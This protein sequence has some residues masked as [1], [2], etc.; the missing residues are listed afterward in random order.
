VLKGCVLRSTRVPKTLSHSSL[1]QSPL[2]EKVPTCRTR[3]SIDCRALAAWVAR[4][5]GGANC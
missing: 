3:K 2:I 5:A 4:S 1:G